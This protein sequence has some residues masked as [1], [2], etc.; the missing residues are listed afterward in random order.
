MVALYADCSC[1]CQCGS[2]FN[3]PL[4]IRAVTDHIPQKY[5]LVHPT[6]DRIGQNSFK[7]LPVGMDIGQNGKSHQNILQDQA[8]INLRNFLIVLPD[9]LCCALISRLTILGCGY[10]DLAGE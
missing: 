10:S 4:G 6:R 5:D 2:F 9:K 7:R 1:L 8:Q 3:A